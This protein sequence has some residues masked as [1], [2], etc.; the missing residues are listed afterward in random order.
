MYG[1]EN[2]TIKKAEHLRID[3]YEQLCWRRLLRVPWTVSTTN[4]HLLRASPTAKQ[5]R[6]LPSDSPEITPHAAMAADLQQPLSEF[7]VGGGRLCSRESGG[8]GL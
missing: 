3:T 5:Q 8:T 4:W 2:W 6:Y 7:R 1:C